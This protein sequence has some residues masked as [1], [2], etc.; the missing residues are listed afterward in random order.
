MSF[1]QIKINNI[2]FLFILSILLA[3]PIL[4]S[5]LSCNK[6]ANYPNDFN[7]LIPN[8]QL[9]P[10]VHSFNYFFLTDYDDIPTM[11]MKVNIPSL[12][13]LK[14]QITPIH[15]RMKISLLF[16]TG[17]SIEKK[18]YFAFSNIPFDYNI[19]EKDKL[20][21]GDLYIKIYSIIP[22]EDYMNID[23]KNTIN[24][25]SFCNEPYMQF[26]F[27]F[28]N[29]EHYLN[30]LDNIKRENKDIELLNKDIFDIIEN[31]RNTDLKLKGEELFEKKYKK[32]LNPYKINT[33]KDSEYLNKY[34][35]NVYKSFDVYIPESEE[36]DPVE[37]NEKNNNTNEENINEEIEQRFSVKKY[38]FKIHMFTEFL[39]GGS[40]RFLLI[41]KNYKNSLTNLTCLFEN[42]CILS[43]KISKNLI[44]LESIL[45]PGNYELL[46]IDLNDNSILNDNNIYNYPIS[47][48]LK[49]KYVKKFISQYNCIGKKIPKNLN[50][51]FYINNN[52]FE[53]KGDISFNMID[54]YDEVYL[55]VPKDNDYILRL[56]T[57]YA[58]GNNINIK[59]YEIE[60]KESVIKKFY[61]VSSYWGG[62]SSLY[63]PLL[64][65]K[66]Y[67]IYFD[68]KDSL[69]LQNERKKCEI[70]Y[71]K[72]SIG[73]YDYLHS[74]YP[75]NFLN[76]N[77][78]KSNNE[79]E[80]DN[81]LYKF[82]KEHNN[83]NN[84]IA[85]G[86]YEIISNNIFSYND[87]DE[88][89]LAFK[90]DKNFRIIANKTFEIETDINFYIDCL[91]ENFIPGIIIPIILP[92]NSFKDMFSN[93]FSD[94]LYYRKFLLHKG[95]ISL[96]LTKGNYTLL[97]VHSLNQF[98]EENKIN[99]VNYGT[100]LNLDLLPKCVVFKL[101]INT[102]LLNKS[103]K[104]NW[105]CNFQKFHKLPN[106]INID[107]NIN[108]FT[109]FNHHILIPYKNYSIFIRNS[110]NSKF[111]LKFRMQYENPNDIGIL[112]VFLKKNN[113][114]ILTAKKE[115]SEE[116][117]KTS[118]YYFYYI[119]KENSNYEIKFDN[120]NKKYFENCKTFT[121]DIS[122]TNNNNI[123]LNSENNNNNNCNIKIPKKEDIIIQRYIDEDKFYKYKETP[124]N[125]FYFDIFNDDSKNLIDEDEKNIF[126]FNNYNNMKNLFIYP[127]Q[128][129]HSMDFNYDFK[130]YTDLARI[131]VLIESP[132]ALPVNLYA[133]IYYYGELDDKNNKNSILI[134]ELIASQEIE[135]ENIYT[136]RGLLL[137]SGIYSIS[138]GVN[139]K[140]INNNYGNQ[141]D[142]NKLCVFFNVKIVIENKGF[143]SFSKNLRE[144]NENCPF[145]EMPDNLNIPGWLNYDTS[146]T[147]SNF[148]RFKIK[149]E[150]MSK[151]FELKEESLFKF[152]LPDED[153]INLYNNIILFKEEKENV[154]KI[155]SKKGRKNNYFL[156]KLDKGKYILEFEFLLNENKNYF[157]V[158]DNDDDEYAYL[159]YYFDVLISIIPVNEIKNFNQITDE[160]NCVNEGFENFRNIEINTDI[161]NRLIK[162]PGYNKESVL[163]FENENENEKLITSFIAS[164]KNSDLS[165]N[166]KFMIEIITNLYLDS[167]F[168]FK[169]Y[170]QNNLNNKRK[171]E[172][173]FSII[174]QDN[175]IWLIFSTLPNEN[176]EINIY[177]R[178]YSNI[179][180][181]S[182]ITFSLS[183]Y[184]E[185]K[186]FFFNKKMCKINKKLPTQFFLD[187][188]NENNNK[189]II[190]ENINLNNDI[191]T[192]INYQNIETG[193]MYFYD[194]FILP[195]ISPN[196][197]TKF[198]ILKKS[199]LIIQI[200][201]QYKINNNNILI[202]I[203][204]D[205]DFY[206][207]ETNRNNNKL[208]GYLILVIN[209][210]NNDENED[211]KNFDFMFDDIENL[212]LNFEKKEE[213]EKFYSK[214]FALDITFDKI[215]SKCETFKILF[216]IIPLKNYLEF[217]MNCNNNN[218]NYNIIPFNLEINENKYFEYNSIVSNEKG[219]NKNLETGNLE[220][221]IN[222]KINRPANLY[223]N[224][225]Y[226]HSNN[227]MDISLFNDKNNYDFNNRNIN[228]NNIYK[229]GDETIENNNNNNNNN[230]GIIINKR[231]NINLNEGNYVIKL[232]FHNIFYEILKE[233]LPNEI[234]NLCFSFYL[235]INSVILP[236]NYI[237][238]DNLNN[239]NYLDFEIKDLKNFNNNNSNSIISIFPHSKNNIKF[240]DVLNINVK[241]AFKDDN[242]ND[243]NIKNYK[244]LIYLQKFDEFYVNNFDNNR[245][246]PNY[247]YQS[248]SDS[249]TFSFNINNENGFMTKNCYKLFYNNYYNIDIN[250][251]EN[252][253][254]ENNN[255][256]QITD[257]FIS[258]ETFLYCMEKCECNLNSNYI[259]GTNSKC[260]CKAPYTGSQCEGCLPNYVKTN[261]GTCI[262][263]TLSQMACSDS[264]TCSGNGYC[265]IPNSVFDPYDIN[266]QNPCVCNEHFTT[267]SGFPTIGFCNACKNKNNFYPF[268][269]FYD[270]D[271]VK[272][273]SSNK[274]IFNWNSNCFEF[275][276]NV[277]FLDEK[278]FLKQKSD[279]ALVYD[280]IL[281]INNEIE[282]TSFAIYEESLIR[283]MFVSK[284]K[285]RASLKLFYN[286]NDENS[287]INT[288]GKENVESF[289]MRLMPR[290]NV[291]YLKIEHF[292]LNFYCNK[293]QL[294][295]EIQP[296]NNVIYDLIN[297]NNENVIK[298][299]VLP[300]N[301]IIL[302]GD[303]NDMIFLNNNF[304]QKTFA[305]NANTILNENK[306]K[307]KKVYDKKKNIN[308]KN[309]TGKISEG[310]I[311]EPF[312]LNIKLIVNEDINF[313]IDCEFYFINNNI[314]LTLSFL[315]GTIL[316]KSNYLI[317]QIYSDDESE[318]NGK[319]IYSGISTILNKGNYIL[320]ISQSVLSNQILQIIYDK[321][322]KK[323]YININKIF[324]TF[325]LN[326]QVN[327]IIRNV[328]NQNGILQSFENINQI[329]NVVPFARTNQRTNQ[330]LSIF[331]KFSKNISKKLKKISENFPLN[332]TFYLEPIKIYENINYLNSSLN[333]FNLITD[334]N[335]FIK[336]KK[337]IYPNYINLDKNTFNIIFNEKSL[338]SN[339]CYK[340]KYNLSRLMSE[341]NKTDLI[342]SD[343][344]IEHK[345]C[346]LTCECNPKMVI[347]NYECNPFN[348]KECLCK[349]P[350]SGF[351]CYECVEGFFK[352]NGKCISQENCNSNFCNNNGVCKYKNDFNSNNNN[353]DNIQ[354]FCKKNFV[355]KFCDVCDDP[356]KKYPNCVDLDLSDYYN[357]RKQFKHSKIIHSP[358]N[359]CDFKFIPSNLNT[360]AYLN[361]DG[362]FHLSEKF[363]I[364][365]IDQKN[366]VMYFS[367]KEITH[368]KIYVESF[369]ENFNVAIYFVDEV[370]NVI[371]QS[372]EINEFNSLINVVFDK[373]NY[374]AVF[375]VKEFNRDENNNVVANEG[376]CK[377]IFV[378]MEFAMVSKE[379]NDFYVVG[380][381]IIKNNN[382]IFNNKFDVF[383]VNDKNN[384]FGNLFEK[385]VF[386]YEK[387][388]YSFFNKGIFK[389][390]IY[391]NNINNN[392]LIN[393][394]YY[395]Y[396]YIPDFINEEYKIEIEIQSKFINNNLNI[397]IEI[398]NTNY[399]T[400]KIK[401]LKS[402]GDFSQKFLSSIFNNDLNLLNIKSPICSF[403]CI[404]GSKKF[405]SFILKRLIPNN[406]FMRIW[407]YE[408]NN[409]PKLP[410]QFSYLNNNFDYKIDF[411][412]FKFSFKLFKNVYDNNN[413]FLK[414]FNNICEFNEIPNDLNN[415]EFL[416]NDDYKKNG[417][418]VLNKYRVDRDNEKNGISTSITNFFI[419]EPHLLRIIIPFNNRIKTFTSLYFVDK[420]NNN[421]E[422]FIINGNKNF[423]EENIAIELPEG[424]YKIVFKFY[425][426][427][428]G[429]LKCECIE[430]EWA[431]KSVYYI[432]S[433]IENMK[434]RLNE[435]KN[436]NKINFN[437]IINENNFKD[438]FNNN[439]TYL[440]KIENEIE[441]NN[442]NK[443]EILM[444]QMP[445]VIA[446][447]TFIIE[448]KNEKKMK[449]ISYISSDF[450]Y[451][452]ASVYL[453]YKPFKSSS[454]KLNVNNFIFPIHKKN[455]NFLST[456]KLSSGEYSLIV[457]YY[458]K[459]HLNPG[460]LNN[461]K[462]NVFIDKNKNSFGEFEFNV[463]II[464]THFDSVN[465]IT[466]KK[467]LNVPSY[468]KS[469]KFSNYYVCR[470]FGLQI[471]KTLNSLRFILFDKE[472]LISDNFIIPNFGF[473]ENEI[474]FEIEN[475]NR[476]IF[477]IFI[478]S[479]DANVEIKLFKKVTN[480]KLKLL[481][482][483]N[484]FDKSFVTLNEILENGKF[485]MKIIFNG[486]KD[487][488]FS[489]N[490]FSKSN[491]K[492]F[493]MTIAFEKNHNY[494]C[495]TTNKNYTSLNE[496]KNK[497]IPKILPVKFENKT[498]F[499]KYD[500][501]I[502]FN[503]VNNSFIYNLISNN[504]SN[505]LF[506]SFSVVKPIDFKFEIFNDFLMSPISV[507][508]KS[509]SIENENVNSRLISE[510]NFYESNSI[511]IVKN[512]PVGT[513]SL[514]LNVPAQKV[515]FNEKEICSIYDIKIEIK[516]S[517]NHYREK[518]FFNNDFNFDVPIMFPLSFNDEKFI[519]NYYEDFYV[520]YDDVFY[521]KF[522][523]TVFD[524][525]NNLLNVFNYIPF[526][527]KNETICN[528]EIEI[529]NK[530][531][532]NENVAI[533]ID[534]INN[535][536]NNL[537]NTILQP[538]SYNLIIKYTK[539]IPNKNN[540]KLSYSFNKLS[541]ILFHFNIGFSSTSRLEKINNYNNIISQS[542]QCKTD[543]FPN[544]INFAENSNTFK[545]INNYFSININEIP[546]NNIL[547]NLSI[548]LNYSYQNR[549][550]AEINADYVLNKFYI[551][552]L[553]DSGKK[554]LMKHKNNV[555]FL[556]LIIP[557][558]KY[559]ILFEIGDYNKIK[560][561]QCLYLSIKFYVIIE[562]NKKIRNEKFFD[563]N[564]IN[565][566]E[567]YN[568]NN[569]FNSLQFSHKCT[570]SLIPLSINYNEK[571]NKNSRFNL[572]RTN[573]LYFINKN[574]EIDLIFNNNNNSL[575][576]VQTSN[577]NNNN[578]N[579]VPKI[580]SNN[581]LYK[582]PLLSKL[583]NNNKRSNIYNLNNNNINN[584]KKYSI[585]FE[586]NQKTN[587]LLNYNNIC[588][589]FNLD[590]IIADINELA[591]KLKCPKNN[592]NK[593][594]L[595]KKP[596]KSI[597][598]IL[599]YT[600]N[601]NYSYLTENEYKS[602]IINNK[603]VYNINFTLN[604]N[605]STNYILNINI[606]YDPL[607][608]NFIIYLYK[609]NKLL[610]KSN[611]IYSKDILHKYPN[612]QQLQFIFKK[613]NFNKIKGKYSI[614]IY[615]SFW[616]NITNILKM[617][618]KN[619]FCLPFSY[620]IE[621]KQGSTINEPPEIIAIYPPGPIIYKYNN[622][623]NLVLKITL[624]DRPLT[625]NKKIINMI[626]N[627]EIFR[628][629]F[630]LLKTNKLNFTKRNDFY[631]LNDFDDKNYVKIFPKKVSCDNS[632]TREWEIIFE[633]KNF[634]ED[635]I[636]EFML[637][638]FTLY[639]RKN[640]YFSSYKGIFKNRVY[641]KTR[642]KV[643][644][645]D[646][647][648]NVNF[649][650]FLEEDGNEDYVDNNVINENLN[651]SGHGK[652]V[653][654]SFLLK[655]I[656]SCVDGFTGKNCEI[657]DG[658]IFDNKCYDNENEEEEN[659]EINVFSDENKIIGLFNNT[660][661]NDNDIN[662]N[663][664]KVRKNCVNGIYDNFLN[665][666]ICNFGFI[667]ELCD[668]EM[669]EEISF[670]STNNNDNKKN[671]FFMKILKILFFIFF[672]ILIMIIIFIIFREIL[673]YTNR[674][675]LKE[676]NKLNQNEDDFA[677]N[678]E[679][680]GMNIKE[681]ENTLKTV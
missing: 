412:L 659:D 379:K 548:N 219:F 160:N 613:E 506:N 503:N 18:S 471:P 521:L 19:Y 356:K 86:E 547:A 101:K 114:I 535:N 643:F 645:D 505:I 389:D 322:S 414:N 317:S 415:K 599:N 41:N 633:D 22:E 595:L 237:N 292:D 163:N 446:N 181:C 337:E 432:N 262:L 98:T 42:K 526:E 581:K 349:K 52:Y 54:L 138:F 301:Q 180:I 232:T 584:N 194:E 257:N 135:D 487:K 79:N 29:Y 94:N 36:I 674:N 512:L 119:L 83:E 566:N 254:N 209:N 34:N 504:D 1:I 171:R 241:L 6:V 231:I 651:C 14:L 124:E 399:F 157:Y 467:N 405:N 297:E 549:F 585:Q 80:I 365:N 497:L 520:N 574:N 112:T 314:E 261:K 411:Y 243:N 517:N 247:I 230:N 532:Q 430:I 136:I 233:I 277:P 162:F 267:K 468:S 593:I 538:K 173:P 606:G 496:L 460:Y 377:N 273:S 87:L 151:K 47:C 530:N 100:Y 515:S 95:F 244:N 676:Y 361:L 669:K 533:F 564:K 626:E 265:K 26:E 338:I 150:K 624:S 313:N 23:I 111:L 630:Y 48:E 528:F 330:R 461:D 287:I 387:N 588:P 341:E 524:D 366:H 207:S 165:K 204:N 459:F 404:S 240:G 268:C 321:N 514:F 222:I 125:N 177:S 393:Y 342:I 191:N 3:N 182:L 550:I 395:E 457:S 279:G 473:S 146:F 632:N 88:S 397:L 168:T 396:F 38:F 310:F 64:K 17:N 449:L 621:L 198:R 658:V 275:K 120:N 315:N 153:N 579:I 159:C 255:N 70:Y 302:N 127:Y 201:P 235:T 49:I 167:L 253:S 422:I 102:I 242:I 217:D 329:V 374:H 271:D 442:T 619:Y 299:E 546:K 107:K 35:I 53:Y 667:G 59:V 7:N 340:L 498:K 518:E 490:I 260:L 407:L 625:E 140:L 623:E 616:H 105:E 281:K 351:N 610:T 629:A 304:N 418:H 474:N 386:E 391:K 553:S 152:Y 278:L 236:K 68:Y 126:N 678:D 223:I 61:S 367:L 334:I 346:T 406:S 108:D 227:F 647:N 605:K 32:P 402:K 16:K 312:E 537:I 388:F 560:N 429:L 319:K 9:L 82:S 441:I 336:N 370:D 311:N 234:N 539:K 45:P 46:L 93:R 132:Y 224:L 519:F 58:D 364:L 437:K 289:I 529:Y 604:P 229:I 238:F 134:K 419:K 491:C 642:N 239:E 220:K 597:S 164:S 668:I 189:I 118:I 654:D 190:D 250:F 40:L 580:K 360:Y 445:I 390:F 425:L 251:N 295:I 641:V 166:G 323:N 272:S 673:K 543:K 363:S 458:P 568:E 451:L 285:N 628:N 75:N 424:F 169:V 211:E 569:E 443:P 492:T 450:L 598:N 179:N 24:E 462:K 679:G 510:S 106:E 583:Y 485:L 353:D 347:T 300:V 183:F 368:I 433:N 455:L 609:N 378:E 143:L 478:N 325:D 646:E 345:Y 494:I 290:E 175:F 426:P 615:E 123:Q 327:K 96:K 398:L 477:R 470:K 154:N 216:S 206:F 558:G 84:Y 331:I 544:E 464:N 89:F 270:D 256:Q 122:I 479:K 369:N 601:L 372:E 73:K 269:S 602:N 332:H 675:K 607:I 371:A 655:E 28:E 339:T 67:S 213:D 362:N 582:K 637:K 348:K 72:M 212:N 202:Q 634:E 294:K 39:L 13:I 210:K 280:K 176:Y 203:F 576:L 170:K 590:V 666:C 359:K 71:L 25:D 5:S 408:I 4:I 591:N 453:I 20:F 636:Y 501:S 672:F 187:Y 307:N 596:N 328:F 400:E 283:I 480:N 303:E 305:I 293:Y 409:V 21:Q 562:N 671:N 128:N 420:N 246:F 542:Q 522:N 472:T 199:I 627:R 11:T 147:L 567:I 155:L 284:D 12:S 335:A 186:I 308:K 97:L 43:K 657:C 137:T 665:K 401:E 174:K 502:K 116:G 259:C 81:F 131:T 326:F 90:S 431:M 149:N 448:R 523:E 660:N 392:N 493:K 649:N 225:K 249:L 511:L 358:E 51:L 76:K 78:C 509:F 178:F 161:S 421:S 63:L 500:S 188:N 282:F 133:K 555:G 572:H 263:S 205:N 196:V 56:N 184:E 563:I 375:N 499:F 612:N 435:N 27:S 444:K 481:N 192:L 2:S 158:K 618:S 650:L 99:N 640:M 62:M 600:E 324:F 384:F 91:V 10:R 670:V 357:E 77:E 104:K 245:I 318:N 333:F 31:L 383:N 552:L 488:L 570:G 571:Y 248:N 352:L 288:D 652:K 540:K 417:F 513:Y 482:K 631:Y 677:I 226:I 489:N 215:L 252:F 141:L 525:K 614:V 103:Y 115:I 456:H 394:I 463:Q 545:Y 557:N 266:L 680:N 611:E 85:N 507:I 486:F 92:L 639:S 276:N 15:A 436:N 476:M 635:S 33:E 554:F 508:L 483:N 381:E 661:K 469:N 320:T 172:I 589:T 664:N 221:I 195:K 316:T 416:G 428:S 113:N 145:I 410:E 495:P 617:N 573:A 541:S 439:K 354:C 8:Y 274:F 156:I 681:E 644:D 594:K 536:N 578:F 296:F 653:Y 117:E 382:I 484:N 139:N 603:F 559:N 413:N 197:R 648:E 121:L 565:I 309:Y 57:Y 592:N 228:I 622:N 403:L 218:N 193:E 577:N 291:Y 423:F 30:R 434:L 551:N 531:N 534:N 286:K 350:Y 376:E 527:I 662:I 208:N 142:F 440:T 65:G 44:S 66:V 561:Y 438:F 608:S 60:N 129:G 663:K 264:E 586:F 69:F 148:Q 638:S 343:E 258:S 385:N 200:L 516:K 214:N 454:N 109:Y 427:S 475:S 344:P 74:F 144:K 465:L 50:F 447:F 298:N 55:T 587:L 556:D 130:I 380:N 575:V 306:F 110:L 620:S 656:C 373:G 355:G 37:Y 452:D 466:E 185:D